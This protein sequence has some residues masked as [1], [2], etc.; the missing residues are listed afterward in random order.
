MAATG[1]GDAGGGESG[2][3][4]AGGGDTGAD[5]AITLALE[6]TVT[7]APTLIPAATGGA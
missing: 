2:V 4:T 5:G 7:R 6:V 3:L 1:A